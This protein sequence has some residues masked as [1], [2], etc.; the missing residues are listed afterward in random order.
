MFDKTI[1][2]TEPYPSDFKPTMSVMEIQKHFSAFGFEDARMLAGAKWD[3]TE[4][5]EGDLIVFNANVLMS[6]Y[7]K[8]WFGDLNLTED[9][10]T[11]KKISESLNTTLYILWEM[12]ARF[13]KEDKPIDE[14][15]GKAVWNTE[16]DKPT[17]EWYRNKVKYEEIQIDGC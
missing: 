16:E 9:Y 2:L 14:L 11:L 17:I 5:H 15:I 12:D 6:G 13:G 4:E 3:Y 7:G 8:V 1:K 10:K